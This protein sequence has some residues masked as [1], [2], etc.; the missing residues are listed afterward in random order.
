MV[1]FISITMFN[2]YFSTIVVIY[3]W[4]FYCIFDYMCLLL[5]LL[6]LL[7]IIYYLLVLLLV[8]IIYLFIY[9]LLLFINFSHSS[10]GWYWKVDVI[11]TI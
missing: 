10:W 9:L 1:K 7:F 8:F 6:L 4:V 5:L 3:G 2:C 11:N